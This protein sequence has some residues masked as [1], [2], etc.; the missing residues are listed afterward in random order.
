MLTTARPTRKFRIFRSAASPPLVLMGERWLSKAIVPAPYKFA[1]D[2]QPL[3]RST[4]APTHRMSKVAHA[5]AQPVQGCGTIF[6]QT[7]VSTVHVCWRCLYAYP[8]A[9]ERQAWVIPQAAR[10]LSQRLDVSHHLCPVIKA[11]GPSAGVRLFQSV[12]S[13]LAAVVNCARPEMYRL[14]FTGR[15][16]RWHG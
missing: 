8:N 11:C 16:L 14:K 6:S 9:Y 5:S 10:G 12:F 1:P 4:S 7:L 13:L 2:T 3:M 15:W